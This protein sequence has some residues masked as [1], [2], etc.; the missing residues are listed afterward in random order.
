MLRRIMIYRA[1]DARNDFLAA[2][3]VPVADPMVFIE[4]D[5]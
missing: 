3:S 2:L 4:H 5:S 1:H